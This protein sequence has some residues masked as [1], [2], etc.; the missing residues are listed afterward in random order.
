MASFAVIMDIERF[1]SATTFRN[2]VGVCRINCPAGI[3]L[4]GIWLQLR[5]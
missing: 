3:A 5:F 4:F 2:M 1:K